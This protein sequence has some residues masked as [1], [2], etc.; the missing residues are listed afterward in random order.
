MSVLT[1]NRLIDIGRGE[2]KT[3]QL[4][5]IDPDTHGTFCAIE[6][7]LAHAFDALDFVHHVAREVIAERDLIQRAVIGGQGHQ[8][9][10]SGRHFFDLQTLLHHRLRQTRL[11]GFEPVLHIH[12]RH[13]GV[14]PRLERG[15]NGCAAQT[16]LGFE[17]H[18]AVGAVELLLNQADHA[19]VQ[20]LGRSAGVNGVDFNFR[21]RHVGVFG[22]RQLRNGQCAGQHNEQRD[23]PGKDRPIDK[24]LRHAH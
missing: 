21:R 24:E 11:H 1:G 3:N 18:Q 13:F 22:H 23:D 10:K 15:G 19:F 12:L 2:V 6:L 16:A 9:Q 5:W 8:H 20:G 17:V 4:L 7:G 14:N